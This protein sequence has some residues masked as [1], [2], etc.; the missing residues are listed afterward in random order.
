MNALNKPFH[1]QSDSEL[2]ASY[3][4]WSEC[5]RTAS[6]WASAYQ[7]AKYLKKT[8]AEAARRG[9]ALTNPFPIIK[10]GS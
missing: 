6:G 2:T 1:D 4:H 5:V 8:C 9:M 10:G 7:A 3:D